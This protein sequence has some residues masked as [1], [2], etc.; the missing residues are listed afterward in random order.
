MKELSLHILDIVT[1]SINAK[2]TLI[3]IEIIENTKEDI[4]KIIIK[5]NGTGI[6]SDD[7]DKIQNP[8]YTTRKVR[9]IGLGLPFLKLAAERCD[10]KF[11]IKSEKNKG[12]EVTAVFKRSHID[13]APLGKI[14]ETILTILNFSEKFDLIYMHELNSNK[15]CFDTREVK[16]IL[17][18][19]NIKDPKILIWIREYI[20]ENI[21]SISSKN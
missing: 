15:F 9:N 7:I 13:R 14:E 18:E 17:E 2:S 3:K 19:D 21:E 8:F 16:D 20:K 10:G 5:D 4:L 12:T 6:K 11:K 1:N